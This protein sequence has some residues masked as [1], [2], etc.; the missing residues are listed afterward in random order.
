VRVAVALTSVLPPGLEEWIAAGTGPRRDHLEFCRLAGAEKLDLAARRP[1]LLRRLPV[2]HPLT[3]LWMAWTLYRRRRSVDVLVVDSEHVGLLLGLLLRFARRRPALVLVVH[4]V[5]TPLKRLLIRLAGG[6]V[7]RYV[8]HFTHCDGVLAA[9]GVL[10]ERR[11]HMPYLV[12]ASFWSPRAA[13]Q[14]HQICAVGLEFRDYGTLFEAVTG[15]DVEV[16]IAVGSPWSTKRDSSRDQSIPANVRVGRRD[17]EGLRRLYATSLFTVVP[18]KENDMQAG[19]TTI[20]ESMAMGRPVIASRTTGQVG[21]VRDGVNGLEVP[22]S[23]VLALRAAIERLLTDPAERE[24][25]GTAARRLVA[26][27]MTVEQFA[28]RMLAVVQELA[29]PAPALEASRA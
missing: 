2:R 12:D 23:D 28:Q 9:A 13:L 18:L 27:E 21:T 3:A 26:D 8:F 1:G 15:L 14:R 19:I 20:V 29:N 25:M 5:S 16:E 17:Y 24:R 7:T 10:P 6:G 4:R 22:P 11:R